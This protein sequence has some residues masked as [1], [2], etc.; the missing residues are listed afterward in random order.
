[1]KKPLIIVAIVVP[2][3][4]GGGV[5]GAALAGVINIPGLTPKRAKPPVP[6]GEPSLPTP[7]RPEA[8]PALKRP[9]PTVKVD[10]VAKDAEQGAKKLASLW[11]NLPVEKLVELAA[12]YSDD[13]LAR[14]VLVMDPE[15]AS[16]LLASLDGKRAATLSKQVQDKASVVP[17]TKK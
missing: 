9:T 2:I 11:N 14:V 13:E 7:T 10:A 5:L 12:A 15:K 8:K 6:Y 17:A 1:M 3:L 16:E 4:L